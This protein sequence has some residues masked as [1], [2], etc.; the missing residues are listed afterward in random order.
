MLGEGLTRATLNAAARGQVSSKPY[1]STAESKSLR[2]TV[3]C[4]KCV[5][6]CMTYVDHPI[7]VLRDMINHRLYEEEIPPKKDTRYP[8]SDLWR[9]SGGEV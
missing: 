6:L 8:L 1:I 2:K 3:V 4:V 7:Q 9:C 5:Q